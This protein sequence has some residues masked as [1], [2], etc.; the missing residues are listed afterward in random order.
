MD[1][2]LIKA[3]ALTLPPL[4]GKP[5]KDRYGNISPDIFVEPVTE[6]TVTRMIPVPVWERVEVRRANG[7]VSTT[8]RV[9]S[10]RTEDG[11][12]AYHYRLR[13]LTIHL[14]AFSRHHALRLINQPYEMVG[15]RLNDGIYSELLEDTWSQVNFDSRPWRASGKQGEGHITFWQEENK[16]DNGLVADYR[17]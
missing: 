6:F 1:Y 16:G 13:P 7:Q 10:H 11:N 4:T 9:V 2:A 12:K 3:H 15:G 17:E 14:D 5:R 8:R